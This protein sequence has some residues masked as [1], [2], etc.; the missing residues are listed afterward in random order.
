M[1]PRPGATRVRSGSQSVSTAYRGGGL[2]C[3]SERQQGQH[4]SVSRSSGFHHSDERHRLRAGGLGYPDT[5]ERGVNTEAALLL[6]T[7]QPPHGA[8]G[9]HPSAGSSPEVYHDILI[10]WQGWLIRMGG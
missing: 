10:W 7:Q 4:P 3:R 8:S 6:P 9:I 1:S 2:L 5:G